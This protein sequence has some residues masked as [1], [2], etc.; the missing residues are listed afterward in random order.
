MRAAAA[1]GLAWAGRADRRRIHH[2]QSQAA[3]HV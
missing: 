1:R 2:R 3:R